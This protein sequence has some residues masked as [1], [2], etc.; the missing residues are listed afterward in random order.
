MALRDV[1]YD[2]SC[3][4]QAEIAFFISWNLPDR[5]QRQ[6]CRLLHRLERNKPDF[7][8]LAHF[9]QRPANARV[10]RQ[11][12]AAIGRMFEGGN[13]GDHCNAPWKTSSAEYQPLKAAHRDWGR[14]RSMS[15]LSA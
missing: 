10:T 3:L 9:F 1:E 5:M 12:L 14:P 7:V 11:S 15:G 6:M 2:R 13:G 8:R 4:E